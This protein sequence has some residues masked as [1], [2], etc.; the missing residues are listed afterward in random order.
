MRLKCSKKCLMS[1]SLTCS[2]SYRSLCSIQWWLKCWVLC[3]RLV[4]DDARRI[5]GYRLRQPDP[6]RES[7][8][9]FKSLNYKVV[10]AG[11]SYNDVPML[12]EAHVG[13]FFHAPERV[14]V[15]H[16]R[17]VN[18]ETYE[19]LT[20]CIDTAMAGFAND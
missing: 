3:H 18:S 7:V 10:S 12:E 1:C 13:F 14:R 15:E 2:M 6:K 20:V 8:K 17:F 9:A 5:V 16:P 19:A 4:V 11:D